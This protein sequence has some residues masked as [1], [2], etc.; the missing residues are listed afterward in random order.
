LNAFAANV[1][2]LVERLEA[3]PYSEPALVP[4]SSWLAAGMPELPAVRGTTGPAGTEVRI[5]PLVVSTRLVDSGIARDNT[6]RAVPQPRESSSRPR[7]WVV[8]ARYADGWRVQVVDAQVR[9]VRLAADPS[10]V[11][12]A[13]ITVT[14]V[15][16][17]GQES[18]PVRVP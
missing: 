10:G 4:P 13:F 15:D 17:V 5:E 6:R 16:R 7:W 12:P 9:T 18:A 14:A 11:G 8:R 3:G 2:Q 1:D